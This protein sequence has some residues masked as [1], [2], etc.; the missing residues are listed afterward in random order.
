M[1]Q[2]IHKQQ[3]VI[4]EQGKVIQTLGGKYEDFNYIEFFNRL[5]K[6]KKEK[7]KHEGEQG[8]YEESDEG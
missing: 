3:Q 2:V 8:K 6:M 5:S 7:E 1:F 4:R